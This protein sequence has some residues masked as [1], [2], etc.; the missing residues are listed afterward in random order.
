[1]CGWHALAVTQSLMKQLL[2]KQDAGSSMLQ[3]VDDRGLQ[4]KLILLSRAQ[5]DRA[6]SVNVVDKEKLSG[7]TVRVVLKMR[8]ANLQL[9][10]QL[11]APPQIAELEQL[12]DHRLHNRQQLGQVTLR[13]PCRRVELKKLHPGGGV[14]KVPHQVAHSKPHPVLKTDCGNLYA[15][16]V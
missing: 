11:N 9:T 4:P 16:S 15:V 7:E 6:K 2:E 10:Q 13:Q 3:G 1:M 14:W 8:L 12:R 5:S